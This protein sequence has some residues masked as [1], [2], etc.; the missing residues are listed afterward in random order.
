MGAY[1]SVRALFV[2]GDRVRK[3]KMWI[4]LGV[5][6]CSILFLG[7][8]D[9]DLWPQFKKNCVRSISPILF[10]IRIPN[11]VCGYTLGSCT[12]FGSL[13]PWHMALILENHVFGGICH[14]VTHFLFLSWKCLLLCLLIQMHFRLDFI[15]ELI[16]LAKTEFHV[17]NLTYFLKFWLCI[18]LNSPLRDPY[19]IP[20][21]LYT[22][23]TIIHRPSVNTFKLLLKIV[24]YLNLQSNLINWKSKGLEILFWSIEI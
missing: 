4:R 21:I 9:L 15:R 20:I 1:S 16:K 19:P 18:R 3:F 22:N 14:I 11:L 13:W 17:L 6:E 24:P 10:E 12:V 2:S 7:R 8:C 5:P 23:N